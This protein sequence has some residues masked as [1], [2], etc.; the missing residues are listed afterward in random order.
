MCIRDR[1]STLELLLILHL[2]KT[3]GKP[4]H[5]LIELADLHVLRLSVV[6]MLHQ[7]ML[8]RAQAQHVASKIIDVV[9]RARLTARE[10]QVVDDQINAAEQIATQFLLDAGVVGERFLQRGA[11]LR[12]HLMKRHQLA[13]SLCGT[14]I[15][16]D[17]ALHLLMR[18]MHGT[19]HALWD[20]VPIRLGRFAEAGRRIAEWRV[21]GERSILDGRLLLCLLYTSPSP[22]D[23]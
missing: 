8:L 19:A 1:T 12:R 22:R 15:L 3:V 23:S 4:F 14:T 17:P 10:A 6:L 5:L 2:L 16:L 18:L 7:T 11:G 20:T 13:E 9:A 21:L